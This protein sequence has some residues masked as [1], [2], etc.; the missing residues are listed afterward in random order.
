MI[1]TRSDLLV[2]LPLII[3]AVSAV[4]VMLVAGFYRR[5]QPVMV[6]TLL[7]LIISL[8]ALPLAASF[9][10]RQVTS[11]LIMDNYALFYIGLI[12]A[13]TF[14]VTVLCYRYFGGRESRHEALYI[15]LL[16]AA[17]GGAVL[18]ASSHFASLLLGLELLSVSLFALIAYP[19]SAERPLEAGIKY[20]ILAG[21]S[22]AFLLFGMAL[23]YAQLGT[24]Q[25]AQ[26]GA[27]PAVFAQGLDAY[28]LAGLA[29]ILVG[30][31]FKLALVPFHMWTPDVYEGAPAPISAFIATVSKGAMLAMLLRYFV[32]ADAHQSQSVVMALSLVA[33][34]T[35]LAG[36]LLAL[37]QD[38]IKRILAYSSI[39]QL[40]Y[41]LVGFLAFGAMAVEAVAYY[42][43]A[44][45]IMML[46]A[47]GVVTVLSRGTPEQDSDMLTDYA[48]LFWRR[49]WLAGVLT[50]MLLSL[51]GIPLTMGFIGKFYVLAAAIGESLWLLV[52]VLAV[53]SAIGL[54]YYLRIIAVMCAQG[55]EAATGQMAAPKV[56]ASLAES[57][58]LTVLALLLIWLGVYPDPLIRMLETTAIH[59][60]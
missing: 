2:L 46:G 14:V 57:F 58:T 32:V 5:S 41:L 8:A 43:A 53:G 29:L 52:I 30:A 50:A 26:I 31:G 11:L 19:R 49:P 44:Y 42:L 4:S 33:I 34:V 56:K 59:L 39:A 48:G 1:L 17:L 20:L 55:P 27:M 18:V 3:V 6:L 28:G 54:Y 24:M 60:T 10:P 47:F 23:I 38:N 37:R 12:F 16:L 36:N 9:G 13:A 22:S 40:G 15:L 35:I 25:F 7:G 21:F 45:F 51:A